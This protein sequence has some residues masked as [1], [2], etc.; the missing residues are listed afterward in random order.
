MILAAI[1]AALLAAPAA[2]QDYCGLA[3]QI[4]RDLRA[5][6]WEEAPLVVLSRSDMGGV[7]LELWV[8]LD[9]Q[10]WTLLEVDGTTACVVAYGDSLDPFAMR[11]AG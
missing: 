7:E 9:T 3:W 11:E 1:L 4:R 2:A 10:S 5:V 8:N 6:P